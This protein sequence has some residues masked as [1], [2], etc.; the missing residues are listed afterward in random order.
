MFRT[1]SSLSPYRLVML[2]AGLSLVMGCREPACTPES[3]ADVT[4]CANTFWDPAL[5]LDPTTLAEIAAATIGMDDGLRADGLEDPG[6]RA[7]QLQWAVHAANELSAASVAVLI[8]A[9]TYDFTGLD[10]AHMSV[11]EAYG[12]NEPLRPKLFITHDDLILRSADEDELPELGFFGPGADG[13]HH[14]R[15]LVL[16]NSRSMGVRL[17]GLHFHG[18]H[19]ETL[20]Q[21][22]DYLLHE[23][24]GALADP[25][26]WG[27]V[28][29]GFNGGDNDAV[30]ADCRIDGINWIGL[31]LIGDATVTGTTIEG[32]IPG[33][34]AGDLDLILADAYAALTQAL[35]YAPGYVFQNGIKRSF[36]Y[37]PAIVTG[38]TFA[39]LAE[40]VAVSGGASGFEIT[41]NRFEAIYDHGIYTLGRFQQSTVSENTFDGAGCFAIKMGGHTNETDPSASTAGAN[42]STITDNHF[43]LVRKGAL[44]LT[45]VDN[46]IEGN[47]VDAYLTADD[48]SGWYDPEANADNVYPDFWMSTRGGQAGWANHTAFNRFTGN[49][50]TDASL[51][52][53]FDQR[54]D[55]EDRS[56]SDN[57]V[58]GQG[59]EAWFHHLVPCDENP[60]PCSD[61]TPSITVEGGAAL[62][63][64]SPPNCADCYPN[65]EYYITELP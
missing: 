36:D 2:L 52:L 61:F 24:H 14:G 11:T 15:V 22:A 28:M 29:V 45:G 9:T 49:T 6:L 13:A 65:A 38:C 34:D 5:D 27:M 47:T 54:P 32:V 37:G 12:V 55:V 58:D 42:A 62:H 1:D 39:H 50:K 64:G 23:N 56:I 60:A 10:E 57:T 17:E 7:R 31:H 21:D 43:R 20:L 35:G 26:R 3:E 33:P 41:G 18:D 25:T 46:V 4:L 48:P 63:V 44:F 30:I 19:D 51:S 59:Q 53:L 40:G 16:I 8:P